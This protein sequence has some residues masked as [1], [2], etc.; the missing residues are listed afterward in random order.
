MVKNFSKEVLFTIVCIGKQCKYVGN[1]FKKIYL[2]LN[3]MIL[4]GCR[5]FLMNLV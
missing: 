4:S 3:I 2:Y 1:K 5:G